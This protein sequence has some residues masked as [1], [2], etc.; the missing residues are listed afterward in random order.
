MTSLLGALTL[1][2]AC[3]ETGPAPEP[4]APFETLLAGEWELPAGVEGY[5]CV[6]LTTE[7]QLTLDALEALAP[8]GTH[9]TLLGVAPNYEGEDGLVPCTAA[10]FGDSLLFGTGVGTD[11][12]E[13]P[14][15]TALVI[16]A[17]TRLVLNL[18]L[19]NA[20]GAPLSGTSG[21]RVR[22]ADAGRVEHELDS[23]FAGPTEFEIAANSVATVEGTCTFGEAGGIVALMPHMHAHGRHLYAALERTDG[24][25]EV[26]HDAAYDF[27]LQRYDLFDEPR[28]VAAGDKLRVRCDF[29]NT[30]SEVVPFGLSTYDEMCFAG[31]LR[32]PRGGVPAFCDDA[33]ESD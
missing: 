7:A 10:D 25:V 19:V 4:D 9:H 15:G 30:T 8:P 20:T 16:E 32:Y 24:S 11:R 29:E 21:V 31:L 33:L 28:P 3:S 6:Y 14:E 2:G 13:L 12:L 17:G 22:A 5:R 23:V 27:E 26:L 18:H 1:A